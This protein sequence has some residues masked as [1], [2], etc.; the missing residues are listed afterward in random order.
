MVKV[1]NYRDIIADR[2]SVRKF[3]DEK[4]SKEVMDKIV[5]AGHLAPTACN[6]QPQRILVID[7]DET[8]ARLKECTRCHFDAP[9]AMLVCYDKSECWT[10]NMTVRAA[11]R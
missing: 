9:T 8:L 2:Y 6:L 4:L 3:R 11:E 10:R 5:E 1:M 7:G